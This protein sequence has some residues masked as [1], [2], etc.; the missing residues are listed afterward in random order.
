VVELYDFVADPGETV[1]LASNRKFS[2]GG[3][4]NPKTPYGLEGSAAS[5]LPQRI[6]PDE[7]HYV[8]FDSL[9]RHFLPNYSCDWT[10]APNFKR[11]GQRTATFDTSYVCSI[12]CMPARRELHT[13]RPTSCTEAGTAGT[14]R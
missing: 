7:V 10:H 3:S 8:M 12:P 9:N 5:R 14:V 13:G 2:A 6:T 11:L 1:N 4:A